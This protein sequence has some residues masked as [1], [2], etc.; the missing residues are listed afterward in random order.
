MNIILLG[1]PG[2]GK[3]TVAQRL[4]QEFHL[5]H[6]STGQ[7]LR[8]EIAKGTTVGKDLKKIIE[9]GDLVPDELSTQIMRLEIKNAK[10]Y[11]LD[12]FPRTVPQAQGIED[13]KVDHIIYLEIAEEEVIERLSGR[14]VCATGEHNYHIK[15]VPPVKSGICDIDGTSLLQRKDDN[16]TVIK[17]RFRVYDRQTKPVIDYYQKKGV[18]KKVNAAQSPQKVYEELKK[19]I[20]YNA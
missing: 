6:I 15:Y 9:K 11:L 10:N 3:G 4:E 7:L 17:E 1:P 5:K 20:S 8:E 2:S 13:L 19:A 16:P 14:R 18:L 12:G